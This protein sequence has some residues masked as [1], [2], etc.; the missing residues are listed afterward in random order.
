MKN[1]IPSVVSVRDDEI[2]VGGQAK[3]RL[4]IDHKNSIALTKREI[5]R[6]VHYNLG[7]NIFTPE[8]EEKR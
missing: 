1:K 2:I 7:G 6:D 5:G 3:S 8:M 4:S